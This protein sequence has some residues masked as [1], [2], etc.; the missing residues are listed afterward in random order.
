MHKYAAATAL[1]MALNI[2]MLA[3]AF[4]AVHNVYVLH[5]EECDGWRPDWGRTWAIGCHCSFE[6][7]RQYSYTVTVRC[8]PWQ[9]T[10]W[11][12]RGRHEGLCDVPRVNQEAVPA[13]MATC[14]KAKEAAHH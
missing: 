14:K 5:E 2:T 11:Q 7:R 9:P 13:C 6:C 1:V 10:Y 8:W 12:Q 4:S 3:P